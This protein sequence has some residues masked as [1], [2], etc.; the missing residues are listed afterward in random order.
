MLDIVGYESD[1]T[2]YAIAKRLKAKQQA[3]AKQSYQKARKRRK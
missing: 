3:K 1:F 2:P